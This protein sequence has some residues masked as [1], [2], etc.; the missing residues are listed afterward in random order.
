MTSQTYIQQ[1]QF[2]SHVYFEKK[3]CV[4]DVPADTPSVQNCPPGHTI[5]AVVPIGQYLKN[6]KNDKHGKNK[7]K[8]KKTKKTKKTNKKKK[9]K[10]TENFSE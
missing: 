10:K 7:N 2:I 6:C 4:Q 3:N 9:K 8:N 1:Q 5:G